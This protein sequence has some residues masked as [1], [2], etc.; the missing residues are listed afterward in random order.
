MKKS[1]CL[2]VTALAVLLGCGSRLSAGVQI[3]TSDVVTE[4][5]SEAK[6]MVKELKPI[7]LVGARNGTFSGKVV[8]E[9]SSVIKTVQASVSPL[10]S[11]GGTIPAANVQ[12][13]Y[14]QPWY[15]CT[16]DA[17][18]AR[19][20]PVGLDVLRESPV[21][22]ALYRG[23]ALVAVWVTVK[24]PKDAQTGIYTGTVTVNGTTVP[25]NLDVQNW[26]LPDPQDYRTWTDIIQSPDTLAMEYKVPLWSEQHWK[27]IDHSF[28]LLSPNGGRVV[29]IP[30]LSH[31]NFG[32]E[33]SMVRWIKKSD[34]QYEYDYTVLDRYLDSVEKNLGK[35]KIVVFAI[36][37]ICLSADA[38]RRGNYRNSDGVKVARTELQGKGP[39]VTALD[40]LTK[41]ASILYLPRFEDPASKALWRSMFAEI[42]KRMAKRG[43]ENNM[44][45]GMTSD[46]MPSKEDVTFWKDVSD[47]LP[48]VHQ[49]HM[50]IP[51]SAV[52]PG[53]K[54]ML[55]VADVGYAA[56]GRRSS[57][58]VNPENGRMYGWKNPV[59]LTHFMR[60]GQMS[61]FSPID[62]REI[63]AF[64][65]TGG[66]RGQGRMGGDYWWVVRNSKGE[67]A[68][69]VPALYPEDTWHDM[70]IDDY[71][72]A[73][74]PNGAVATA[75]LEYMKEGLQICEAR[76]ALED[77]LLDDEKKAKIG[78]DLAKRCQEALDEHQHAMW[79]T[80]WNNDEDLKS[81]KAGVSETMTPGWWLTQILIMNGKVNKSECQKISESEM[82]KGR[83]WYVLGRLEREKKLFALAGEVAVKLN[84]PK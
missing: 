26:T 59:L 71:F 7:N 50:A 28:Q 43:L 66:H 8:V 84:L 36:W 33:Q 35:P 40:P 34:N 67:R 6:D 13:R 25:L 55:K 16:L 83:A 54:G 63:L 4:D 5:M 2:V 23:R 15:T 68:G 24:V 51:D 62:M 3:W 57:Y 73:P 29:Y 1:E 76:I 81:V 64:D 60:L 58:N 74:G 41:E 52:G 72:L 10:T 18:T 53:R 11:K 39:R 32:N 37:D 22:T 82:R 17:Y 77:A 70:D 49:S 31:M 30:L 61:T 48:W 65:I 47:D 14:G 75:R 79:K 69:A 45:L 21:E 80:I 42:R 38:V 46:V 27:L 44:M 19:L 20:L 78:A 12:I 56:F 9:S